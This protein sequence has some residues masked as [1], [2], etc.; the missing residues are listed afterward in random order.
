MRYLG[1]TEGDRIH[2]FHSWQEYPSATEQAFYERC[3]HIGVSLFHHSGRSEEP[4]AGHVGTWFVIQWMFFFEHSAI[5]FQP[6]PTEIP[7]RSHS[8]C[9]QSDHGI[10]Q[11][12]LA[13]KSIRVL[14]RHIF[15]GITHCHSSPMRWISPGFPIPSWYLTCGKGWLSDYLC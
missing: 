9:Q 3:M 1:K 13:S 5:H 4:T 11:K 8:W 12:S 6:W 2:P 10:D 15:Y 7:T 14:A